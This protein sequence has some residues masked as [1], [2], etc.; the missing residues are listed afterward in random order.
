MR[1]TGVAGVT[2]KLTAF[3]MTPLGSCT[4]TAAEP[5]LVIRL[6]GITAVNCVADTYVVPSA[7]PFHSTLS[8]L[9]KLVPFTVSV[10]PA[11]PATTVAGERVPMDGAAVV[12]A[13]LTEFDVPPPGACTLIDAVL[14][15]MIRLDGT[16]AVSCVAD[17]YVVLSAE[18]FHSTLSPL[19]KLVPFTVSVNP[20]LPATTVAGERVPMDGAAAVIAKLTEF[21][22][23]PPGA[24]TLIDAVLAVM[25]RLDGTAAVSCVA[26]TYVVPSAEPFH[27][28]LSPLT[29]L[30]PFTVSVNPALPATTVAGE[31]VPMDGAAA[32]IA[33]LTEFDVP[34]PGACTLIDAV[35]AV[36]IR[37]DGTAAVNCVA[38]TYVVPSAE[39]FHSTLSPLTKLVPFTVSVNPAL[40]ATTV[41][42]EIEFKEGTGAGG[43]ETMNVTATVC[44]D[45]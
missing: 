3:D 20:A 45:S 17:T 13:K 6:A 40:P 37:L 22:V 39:P 4:V 36:V 27:S 15:V 33:K 18:P 44:G 14:A 43:G 35:L 16:A 7:E 12:I 29:K 41:A 2:V 9:T 5:V 31:S 21:D 42:G 23:P 28:T 38:D 10:N 32:V 1:T 8:P 24:C 19:T 26:D 25:I 11:L 30:V 34:P